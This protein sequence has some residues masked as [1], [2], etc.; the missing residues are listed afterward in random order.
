MN[1]LGIG[2]L[3]SRSRLDA[4]ASVIFSATQWQLITPAQWQNIT[5][6]WN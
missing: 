3:Y 5:D 6:T 2:L 1:T 4:A